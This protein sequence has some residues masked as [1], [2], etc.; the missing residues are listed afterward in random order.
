MGNFLQSCCEHGDVWRHKY[1]LARS[2]YELQRT[3]CDY[4]AIP[5]DPGDGPHI[6]IDSAER[7][8]DPE[9]MC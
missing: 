2:C 1:D 9:R 6:S 4:I 8:E 7:I 5:G 3:I